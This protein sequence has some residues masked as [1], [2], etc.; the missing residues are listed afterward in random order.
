MIVIIFFAMLGGVFMALR[1]AAGRDIDRYI[2][3]HTPPVDYRAMKRKSRAADHEYWDYQFAHLQI[4][5]KQ[6]MTKNS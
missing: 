5:A 3:E 4:A 1:A 2:A 6:R